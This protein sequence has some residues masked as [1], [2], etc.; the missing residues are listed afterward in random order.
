MELHRTRANEFDM[1]V[2]KRQMARAIELSTGTS[3]LDIGCGIGL[4]TEMLEGFDRVTGLDISE[5]IIKIAKERLPQ[6]TFIVGDAENFS[7]EEKFDTIFLI[8]ILEHLD[9]PVRALVIASRHLN[10]GGRLVIIV[11]NAKSFNRQIGYLMGL[12]PNI[13]EV[14]EEQIRLYDHKRVYDVDLLLK[15]IGKAGLIPHKVEGV[16]FKPLTNSQMQ[17]ICEEH[18]VGWREDL[19]EALYEIGSRF[20]EECGELCVVAVRND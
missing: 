8:N 19:I 9:N 7:V 13:Y 1:R 15:D 17:L 4:F 5:K 6:H 2:G 10:E 18:D 3:A 12:I 14:G 11:P 20:P 16:I